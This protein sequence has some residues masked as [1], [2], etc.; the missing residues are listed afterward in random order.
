M[1]H[2][3]VHDVHLCVCVAETDTF[4]RS[5]PHR[6]ASDDQLLSHSGAF[7]SIVR[8]SSAPSLHCDSD[9][10]ENLMK[11]DQVSREQEQWRRPTCSHD[12]PENCSSSCWTFANYDGYEAR[13]CLTTDDDSDKAGSC[14]SMTQ[15]FP[16]A[17]SKSSELCSADDQ[18]QCHQAPASQST[19]FYPASW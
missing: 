4:A 6:S 7:T 14:S 15:P 16:I 8:D 11:S 1:S 13:Q 10:I 18:S 19:C 3:I 2:C 12:V 5:R 17:K 9:D